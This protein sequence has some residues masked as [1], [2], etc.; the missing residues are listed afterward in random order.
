VGLSGADPGRSGAGAVLS[1]VEAGPEAG[2]ARW[3]EARR[4]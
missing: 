1:A 4:S 2:A 3:V